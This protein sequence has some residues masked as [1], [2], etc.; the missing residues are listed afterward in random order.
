MES[1]GI[2]LIGVN[3]ETGRKLLIS[4]ALIGIVVILRFLLHSLARWFVRGA[5]GAYRRRFWADQGISLL[6]AALILLGLLSIWFDD[7][8]HLAAAAGVFTAGLAFAMQKVIT[9]IAGYFV[10]LRGKTFG[11]GDRVMMGGVRG[12]VVALGFIQTTIMEMGQPPNL[13]GDKSD[14]WVM[15]RQ[16]SGRIVTVNNSR[17]FE[18]PVYNYTRDFPYI[19]DE[20][21]IPIPY[22]ADR[23]RAEE[24]LLQAAGRHALCAEKLGPGA[25]RQLEELY[26][27]ET[28][29]LEPRVFYRLT[30]NWLELSMRFLVDTHGTRLVKDA[31][32]R[33]V[34]EAFE[35][36]G[37]K[38]ASTTNDIVGFPPIEVKGT[39]VSAS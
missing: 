2:K 23:R 17:I 26:R 25:T 39:S 16:F 30:D 35:A 38:I 22:R 33:E 36:A 18:E 10:I 4:L 21:Q 34:I 19:W 13:Q 15:S 29:D 12:D 8:Q 5:E 27:I 3:Y 1:F 7:P 28:P 6:C 20:M 31:I 9:A 24:I 37:I 32:S 11:V 14:T